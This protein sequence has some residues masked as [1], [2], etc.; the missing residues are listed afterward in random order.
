[1]NC[2]SCGNPLQPGARFCPS[3]G[4]PVAQQPTYNAS[5][6]Q[7]QQPTYNQPYQQP[8]QPIYNQPYQQPQAFDQ[9]WQNQPYTPAPAERAPLGLTWK[10]FYNRYVS[11]KSRNMVTWMIVI[12]FVTAAISIGVG[13]AAESALFILDL[14]VYVTMGVLLLSTK[15]WIFAL[16]P[17]IYS[18]IWTVVSFANEGTP[19]GIAALVI[20][21][22]SVGLLRKAGKAYTRYKETGEVPAEEL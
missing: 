14:M 1:M 20:G 6:Q 18:G 17:T 3:C 12:C 11:K 10:E 8:Q 16:L 5:W 15:H 22:G 13:V 19:S 4:T 2:T 9:P 7:P 21:I